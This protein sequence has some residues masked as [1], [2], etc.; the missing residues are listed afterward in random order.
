MQGTTSTGIEEQE[1]KIPVRVGRNS[2][3]NHYPEQILV[4][5]CSTC[6]S[7]DSGPYEYTPLLQPT[8]K[9]LL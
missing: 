8:Q 4:Y 1:Y 2:N 5:S 3:N 6:T 7:S 9:H